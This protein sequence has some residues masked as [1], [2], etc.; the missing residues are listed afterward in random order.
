MKSI[1]SYYKERLIEISG[2]NRSL[3]IRS[4]SKKTG[5]DLGRILASDSEWADEFLDFLWMGKKDK[6]TVIS[7]SIQSLKKIF[8]GEPSEIEQPRPGRAKQPFNAA[9]E[10]E[11]NSVRALKR[12]AEDIEKETGR[13]ELFVGYPFVCGGLRDVVIKAPLLFFPV[14]VE[15]TESNIVRLNIKRGESVRLNKAFIFAYAQAKSLN[16]EELETE[17]DTLNHSGMKDI[18][19]V[20]AYLKKF[21]IRLRSPDHKKLAAFD[22]IA[23]PKV[24]DALELKRVCVLARYSMANSIYNDYSELERT[25]LTNDAVEELFEP[26]KL[27]RVRKKSRQPEDCYCISDL[28]YAQRNVVEKVADSGNMVIYG[29][30][31]T[32][33]S[34]TIVNLISDA[35]CKGKRVLVVSQKKAALDVVYNR[36]AALSEKAMFI[37]DPVKERRSFYARC[38]AR[39][40]EVLRKQYTDHFGE[41]D[42]MA[43]LL[44]D[45]IARLQEI[46]DTFEEDNGFGISLMDM[47]YGSFIPGKD[48]EEYA[49]YNEMLKDKTLRTMD[50]PTMRGAIDTLLEQDK[51][52]IYYNFVENKKFNPFI[53]HL[54]PD[55]PIDTL[56][57]ARSKFS[58]LTGSRT[59]V[60]DEADYPF[61]RQIIAQYDKLSNPR[62]EKM[63]IHMLA[64]F[65][66]PSAYSFL[67]ASKIIFFLYPFAKFNMCR[68]EKEVREKYEKAKEAISDFVSDY[69]FLREVLTYEGYAMALGGILEGN[70][71]TM[72]NLKAAL[73]DYVKVSDVSLSLHNFTQTERHILNFAYRMTRDYEH[74]RGVIVKLL[75]LRVYH[76]IIN[77]EKNKKNELS[78]TVDFENIKARINTLT[79]ELAEIS[80]KI[81][82]N[83]FIPEYQEM[84][85]H[86]EDAKDYLYQISKKQNYWPLRRTME[87]YGDYLL[88]LYPCWLLSPEN[89]SSIL[90]LRKNMFDLVLFDEASQVFIENTVPSI[91]RGKN[92]V[93]AGDAKQLRPTTTF[94]RRYMGGADDESD[95]TLQAALE[96]ESLLDL[97]VA[98]FDSANITYH[99]RSY[100]R[101]LIDFSNKAFYD[102]MLRISPD[103]TKSLKNKAIE[104]IKVAGTWRDRRN[105][106]EAAE[107]VALLK[108]LF[109]SRSND[110]IG[111]ITFGMEQQTCI[112]DAIDKECKQSP[113]FRTAYFSECSR[114][115]NGQDVSLFIKN[116][117]NVQGDERDIIIFSIGYAR[118]DNDKVNA[119]FGSLSVE[120]GENRLNVA[121]T[122]AKKKIY[123]ITSIEPEDLRVDGSKNN[124]PKLFRAY[125]AYA[126]AVSGGNKEEVKAVLSGLCPQSVS[127]RH[128]ELTVPVEQQIAAKLRTL[129]YDVDTDIG[130]GTN[131]ISVAVYDKKKDKYVLGIQVDKVLYSEDETPLERDVYACR[132]LEQKGWNIMRVWS[133]DW[134]HNAH[135]VTERIR[136]RLDSVLTHPLSR[137]D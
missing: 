86:G 30:P 136:H 74:F 133:R 130:S 91:I 11:A 100:S 104:R 46:S 9:L 24:R 32:G 105:P 106:V 123:V 103:V 71:N 4:F 76:E 112:E 27:K 129:G 128:A 94:M 88:T 98:R 79:S 95:L 78:A 110:T 35:L 57:Y 102:G 80:R 85:A 111:I 115:D 23:E 18:D 38:L 119:H 43:A 2:K 55:L 50:Y 52:D 60:F 73:A 33:K 96:V 108:K 7:P 67:Q 41:Y 56:S 14:E 127:V 135:D 17:F 19:S 36:L 70:E 48:S 65:E 89:V 58:E 137:T 81:C 20:L 120:G 31:G 8:G 5:Y 28:D 59:A 37:V 16:I 21:G 49:I 75:P 132:F 45:E 1:Y 113:E 97:A 63:F 77:C 51:I 118:N 90:P 22:T 54:K 109:K 10:R 69:D 131:K 122:R 125:L 34:Q 62:N 121:V 84:Y 25:R 29:P 83:S 68:K 82:A 72:S 101:G 92:V 126:R 39:H 87:I 3:Y 47:Y 93:V 66:Y 64:G 44:D 15:I 42:K 114:K 12:E 61:A 26:Q 6:F 13:Y 116:I 40:E 124:G 53:Q 107:T 99:Y 134:W 117:E